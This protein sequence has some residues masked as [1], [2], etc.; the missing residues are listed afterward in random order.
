MTSKQ[1]RLGAVIVFLAGSV[2]VP[3][4]AFAGLTALGLTKEG[5]DIDDPR[6][7]PEVFPHAILP[8][9]WG[10]LILN[11]ILLIWILNR[12]NG[13]KWWAAALIAAACLLLLPISAIL[14][15]MRL[16]PVQEQWADGLLLVLIF[17]AIA[18]NGIVV[19]IA[20]LIGFL[21]KRRMV[22]G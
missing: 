21:L 15:A 9:V 4:F 22:R 8:S 13:F 7:F 19:G 10:F 3:I 6:A 20:W 12:R 1:N 17:D 16:D 5:E 2:L 14:V 11:S 18:I